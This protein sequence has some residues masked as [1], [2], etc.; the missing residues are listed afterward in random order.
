MRVFFQQEGV[1]SWARARLTE[2][3][4]YQQLG[5]PGAQFQEEA[6]A[7]A[8]YPRRKVPV[9]KDVEGRRGARVSKTLHGNRSG[10]QAGP[11]GPE[12]ALLFQ[13]PSST[14]VQ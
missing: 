1:D 13:G 10:S 5:R 7:R 8:W 2:V 3:D 12:G 4:M 9:C 14:W 11:E 6:A